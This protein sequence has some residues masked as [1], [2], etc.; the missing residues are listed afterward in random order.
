LFLLAGA[1]PQVDGGSVVEAPGPVV[2]VS[3]HQS[4]LDAL[5]L[6]AV[7][8]PRFGFVAKRELLRNYLV[9]LALRRLGSLFV[10]RFESERSVVDSMTILKAVERGESFVFFPEGTFVRASGLL[11][12]RMGAFTAAAQAGVPIVPVGIKGTRAALR[13]Q[14]W[15]V[16]RAPL[17]VTIGPPLRALSGEWE[18]SVELMRSARREMLELSGEHDA[19]G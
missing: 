2:V 5:L 13:A 1:P 16:N 14:S 9:G 3:N 15:F 17:S 6:T 10:E 7:L 12:F 18:S 11:A 19:A 4:Y 8:P